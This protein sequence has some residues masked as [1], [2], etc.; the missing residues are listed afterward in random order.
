MQSAGSQEDSARKPLMLRHGPP[1]AVPRDALSKPRHALARRSHRL[2]DA[3]MHAKLTRGDARTK[4]RKTRDEHELR[5]IAFDGA[6]IAA[7][8]D[9]SRLRLLSADGSSGK[10]GAAEFSRR[11][12]CRA[13]RRR[14]GGAG[15]RSRGGGE[16]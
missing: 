10:S 5:T 16:D 11:R 6:E 7:V 8:Q 13:R 9:F 14:R 12:P 1:F 15:R 3:A 4:K 2:A